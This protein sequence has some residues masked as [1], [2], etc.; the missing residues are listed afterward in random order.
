MQSNDTIC[1]I[2]TA[3]G[4]AIGIIR[5]SGDKSI[6]ILDKIF[7][8][9]SGKPL[10]DRKSHT[11]TFGQIKA[12]DE[13]ILDEVLVSIFRSP[14][15]YTGEESAE[16][17]CHGSK[18]ILQKVI[19]TLI[20][21]GCRLA[22]PGEFTQRAFLNKK[23]DLSQAEA[24]ADLIASSSSASH[25]LAIN[26]MRGRYSEDLKELRN[27][28]LHIASLL[29]LELDFSDHEELE[30]ASRDEV[31]ALLD[32]TE[33]ELT[34]LTESFSMGN[35]MKNGIP[36]AIVG[37]TNVGKSTLLNAIIGE[38]RA[39]VSN[40]KGT[41]RDAIEDIVN[42]SGLTFRFIDT[43]GIRNTKDEVES[44]GINLTFQKIKQAQIILWLIDATSCTTEDNNIIK[45]ILSSPE[46]KEKLIIVFNK[47]DKLQAHQRET[48][49]ENF[50]S[51]NSDKIFI[52]AKEKQG[53]ADL[54]DLLI[55]KTSFQELNKNEV[56]VSNIRHYEALKHA[57]VAIKRAKDTFSQNI[58]SD[59]VSQ[60][61]RDCIYH[62]N[63]ISGEIFADD[64]LQNIFKNFCIG[65]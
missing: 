7:Y 61:I 42:I 53:I 46:N 44:I 55:E 51:I 23:M 52:S 6:S 27:K 19:E 33:T 36:V 40:I 20:E 57:L 1:A 9:Q 29:E 34:K 16:I 4:G 43:A 24:V 25:N 39:I 13:E 45:D 10:S 59:I 49:V 26:Q 41:T 17:S 48:I 8:P 58:S 31:K 2:A 11:L 12:S 37:E 30:F 35:S 32:K 22:S 65:K 21:K 60:D 62:L 28:L 47:Q 50:S 3:T 38:D 56:I 15:S 5:L 64:V 18:Y 54:K 14:H 63:E